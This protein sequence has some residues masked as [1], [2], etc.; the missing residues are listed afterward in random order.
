MKV[1]SITAESK[2]SPKEQH[3]QSRQ[4]LGNSTY[5]TLCTKG[6]SYRSFFSERNRDCHDLQTA[7]LVRAVEKGRKTRMR[8]T[9]RTTR[10]SRAGEGREE[11]ESE[12]ERWRAVEG[13][14][15]NDASFRSQA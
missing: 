15:R 13:G 9:S 7:E 14:R 4:T 1:K 11:E 5:A 12:K 2:N 6:G 8:R 3:A 10:K